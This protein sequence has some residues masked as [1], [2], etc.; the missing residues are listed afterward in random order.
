MFAQAQL[1]KKFLQN[2]I[3]TVRLTLTFQVCLK[4]FQRLTRIMSFL[5]PLPIQSSS[6]CLP[7]LA[8]ICFRTVN[9]CGLRQ[10]VGA[11]YNWALH[12]AFSDVTEEPSI[13]F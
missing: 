5:F 12:K 1:E 11:S 8:G 2:F 7:S 4:L 9:F 10:T 13:A 6:T 3:I